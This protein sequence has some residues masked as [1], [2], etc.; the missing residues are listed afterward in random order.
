MVQTE[1]KLGIC[2]LNSLSARTIDR[3]VSLYLVLPMFL[4]ILTKRRF[5]DCNAMVGLS[6]DYLL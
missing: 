3:Y 2:L 6:Y 4:E 5:L 1:L